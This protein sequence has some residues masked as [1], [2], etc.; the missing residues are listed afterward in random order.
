MQDRY[1]MRRNHLRDFL[2]RLH[3]FLDLYQRW[4]EC[5]NER[6]IPDKHHMSE[7]EWVQLS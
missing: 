1:W 6:R 7:L 4:I 3:I 5:G 2:G